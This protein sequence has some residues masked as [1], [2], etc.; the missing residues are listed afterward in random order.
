MGSGVDSVS[1]IN[2]YLDNGIKGDR[3]T[4][5]ADNLTAF[6]EPNT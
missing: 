5:K 1:N 3:P 4:W 2:E 6:Y